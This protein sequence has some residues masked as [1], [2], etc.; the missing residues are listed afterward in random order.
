MI[1]MVTAHPWVSSIDQ[2][3]HLPDLKISD[4]LTKPYVLSAA[5]KK[6]SSQFNILVLSQA[7]G[8]PLEDEALLLNQYQ[9]IHCGYAYIR[10]VILCDGDKPLSFG[11]VI[12]P[13][14]TYE[15]HFARINETGNNPFGERV[16]YSHPNFERSDF[17]FS[18]YD[19]LGDFPS[20]P[21]KFPQ[22]LRNQASWGRRSIFTLS[23]LPLL[24][25]ELFM[26]NLP[27]YPG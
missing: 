23:H 26:P 4:W 14:L 13:G 9:D 15:Q 7:F 12:I 6:V 22:A 21:D 19:R 8:V 5:F 16:L 27:K 24:V 1:D 18:Y 20:L 11:R 17:E 25:V 3:E 10:Q 2:L